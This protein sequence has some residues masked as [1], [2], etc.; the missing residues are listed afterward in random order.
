MRDIL[1]DRYSNYME[2]LATMSAYVGE[3]D[4]AD[5]IRLIARKRTEQP[6]KRKI[7]DIAEYNDNC[8][9]KKIMTEQIAQ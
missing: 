6:L 7:A 1:F 9:V 4:L 8:I 2:S 3:K 5:D